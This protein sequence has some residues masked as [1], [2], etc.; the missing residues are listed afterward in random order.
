MQDNDESRI[1]DALC[2]EGAKSSASSLTWSYLFGIG[3][4]GI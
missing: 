2:A 1:Q 4:G 3:E